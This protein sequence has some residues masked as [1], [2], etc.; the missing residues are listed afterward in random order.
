MA[1]RAREGSPS[2]SEPFSFNA[3]RHDGKS[4]IYL[5]IFKTPYINRVL[6][7]NEIDEIL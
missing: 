2:R 7:S 3:L 4:K 5:R 6:F 1:L